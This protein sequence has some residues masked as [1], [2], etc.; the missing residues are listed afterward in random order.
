MTNRQ[1]SRRIAISGVSRGLGLAMAEQFIQR[2]HVVS[3][4]ARSADVIAEL[5]GRWAR[6]H[7]W[8]AVDVRCDEA[9]RRWAQRVLSCG[10]AP[11]LLV[12]NAAVINANA[13]L[14]EVP[15]ERRYLIY[16]K[17]LHDHRTLPPMSYTPGEN[18][19]TLGFH[20]PLYHL[21]VTPFLAGVSAD[22][23]MFPTRK[24]LGRGNI[25]FFY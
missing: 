10:G 17:Y 12:N 3:G 18:P 14:W 24:N 1:T 22:T 8:Q 2:G 4:C 25:H 5:E 16:I 9:V 15:D 6:P 19:V 23:G 11:D 13:P 20:Q 21:M 7:E